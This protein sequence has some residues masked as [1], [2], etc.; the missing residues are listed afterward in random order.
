MVFSVVH[1]RQVIAKA[2]EAGKICIFTSATSRAF[3]YMREA[4]QKGDIGELV[5]SALQGQR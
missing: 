1:A 3:R 5:Q 2:E 4:F